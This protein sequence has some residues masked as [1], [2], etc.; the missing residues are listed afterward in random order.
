MI[1]FG[2]FEDKKE[3]S[4]SATREKVTQHIPTRNAEFTRGECHRLNI[5]TNSLVAVLF[6]GDDC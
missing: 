4:Q 1:E 2:V 5:P 6:N 3:E